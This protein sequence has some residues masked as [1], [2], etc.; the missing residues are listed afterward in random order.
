MTLGA[1]ILAVDDNEA[2]SSLLVRLL[3]KAGYVAQAEESG[4]AALAAVENDPPDLLLLDL[5]LKGID[6]LEVCRRL[7]EN[8][9]TEA[10]PIILVS[11][12]ADVTEWVEGLRLGAADYITKPFQR[13]ELLSRV[14]THLTLQRT[15]ASLEK[16]TQVLRETNERLEREVQDRHHIESELRK[17]LTLAEVATVAFQNALED[18]KQATLALR[19]SE[20]KFRCLFET[21]SDALMTLEP[22]TW[23]LASANSAAVTLF[24]ASNLEA[25]LGRTPT[26]LAPE[27]QPDGRPSRE[28]AA[29]F[30]ARVLE[31]GTASYPWTCRRLSGTLFEGEVNLTRTDWGGR[32]CI[33]ATVRDVSAAK[34]IEAEH[35]HNRKLEAVGQL[36]AGIAHEINTPAQYVGDG[37]HF[38]K[39]AF[40][41]YQQLLDAFER[42]Q[43]ID[44][45]DDSRA[46]QNA[47]LAQIAQDIDLEYLKANVPQALLR[48]MDGVTR[49]ATIVRAMKEFAHPDQREMAP[50]DINQA[51]ANTLIIARTEYKYV[52]DIEASYGNIP[53]VV[54]HI[55]D[56]G[57][58]FLNLIVNASQAIAAV[59]SL[60]DE[61][62]TIRITTQ[63]DGDY[64]R[65]DIG[66]TGSGVPPSIRQRVFDP[67][68]TTKEVG[69]GSGQGLAISRSIIVTKHQGTLTFST[70]LGE[71]TTF[72]VRLPV[73]GP[74]QEK[75]TQPALP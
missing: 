56:I 17:S 68:F 46:I 47:Q 48:C 31:Y 34:R 18:H 42:T 39:E 33:Q 60:P 3:T 75:A 69:K 65:V 9:R 43:G 38:L 53:P 49:I 74:S 41:G 51:L 16:Q 23:Q 26:E 54:C 70:E 2:V 25:L 55:G 7:K 29:T 28:A 66:D 27:F 21:S 20:E 6:G 30:I 71:G 72:T 37:L 4:E 58:V 35:A 57:Q 44:P 64:V 40:E 22:P 63:L 62:G 12:F 5:R 1:R 73:L 36:A 59:N 45:D 14:R 15:R 67:F 8:H 19:E 10:V 24:S 11:A 13:D 61:R 50:A 32:Q 52:A